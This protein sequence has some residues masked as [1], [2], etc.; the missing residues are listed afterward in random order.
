MRPLPK[1]RAHLASE[2]NESE[3]DRIG[4]DAQRAADAARVT[5]EARPVTDPERTTVNVFYE[6]EMQVKGGLWNAGYRAPASS[7]EPSPEGQR[8]NMVTAIRRTLDH[9][10]TVNPRV[11]VFGE[12][13]GPKGGVH[14][15]TLGLQ[16]KFGIDRVFDTSLS[17]EGII[18]PRCRH[19]DVGPDARAGNPVP[20]ICRSRDRA[21]STTAVRCAGAPTTVSPRRWSC[22]CR[23]ASSNAATPGTARPNEVQFV[24]SP[25]WKVAVPSNAEDAVGP[26]AREPARQRSGD[27]FRAS[28]D[29]G[30]DLGAATHIRATISFCRSARRESCARG[31]D[32]TIVTW[33]AM[34]ERCEQAAEQSSVEII[35]LR[36]L[37]PWDRD[38]VPDIGETHA[39]LPD[40]T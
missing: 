5:A 15:V 23:S 39:P 8:I 27:L 20:Q 34:V 37:M 32:L 12:D 10:L 24:H 36:T 26:P 40:R 14:A 11:L 13:I 22:A 16:E 29:A 30:C 38:A 1:L 35:D 18:G 2:I 6:D 25:G 19:G 9:E 28:R 3:W 7:E 17:E 31:G 21:G 4:A 33:G